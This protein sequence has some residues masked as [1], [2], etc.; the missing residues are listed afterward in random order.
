M[1]PETSTRTAIWLSVLGLLLLIPGTMNLPLMDRDEPRFSRAA[2]EMLERGT[3][4]IPYFNGEYRFDKP[5]L[6]YWL[7]WPGLTAFG[8]TEIA[9]RL[10]SILESILCGL[11]IFS[12]GRR[13]GLRNEA[14]AL[15]SAAWFTCL[16]VLI[17][18]RMAVADMGLLV[19]LTITMR[20]LWELSESVRPPA[21]WRA[22]LRSGWF[23]VLWLSL[24]LGFLAK[25]PLAVAVP[26]TAL[27]V[28]AV[29]AKFRRLENPLPMKV[30]G[31]A[32][33]AALIPALVL[34][35]IWG[36]PALIET[37]GQ[38]FKIGIGKHVIE[39]GYESFNKRVFIP[40]V[41]Y[42]LVLPVF[43]VPWSGW[44]PRIFGSFARRD[45][46]G[47]FL[48]SWAAAPFLIFSF[49]STQLPHYILPGYPALVL[50]MAAVTGG[51]E[52]RRPR[53]S[54]T[55]AGVPSAA[56][57][58][59]GILGFWG[60]WRV[61]S[62]DSGLAMLLGGIGGFAVLLGAACLCPPAGKPR[63][64]VALCLAAAIC[65]HLAAQGGSDCHASKRITERIRHE[66]GSPGAIDYMEP[67]LV[68]YLGRTWSF[69]GTPAEGD[70]IQIALMRKWRVD[71][72]V[73]NALIH[74]G[75][76]EPT[77]DNRKELQA[78][79]PE[80]AQ[81]VYGW[82]PADTSWVELAFWRR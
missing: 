82:S 5:P 37:D 28:A 58:L 34:V 41:Y 56:L 13:L 14:A 55:L 52:S 27:L 25:G 12:F 7:M 76:P 53:L 24:G 71:D 63:M 49:Y 73:L 15:A 4:I 29:L 40:G 79:V 60:C 44:L 77:R 74:N 3:A 48:T 75:V 35:A 64:A 18:S 8:N 47:V 45:R 81:R 66:S 59:V 51:G 57:F 70:G 16:Q 42:L 20:A 33:A 72:E 78:W 17:H 80:D 26:L 54:W 46:A 62:M 36:I 1:K 50:L 43:F 31:L 65:F 69:G 21:G 22:I 68:W 39:R 38:F 11:L 30:A 61:S 6:S 2:V 9:V 67:S 32:W 10:P 19:F 23:H